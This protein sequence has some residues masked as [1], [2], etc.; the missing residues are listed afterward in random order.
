MTTII[1][2]EPNKRQQQEIHSLVN[3]CKTYE[4]IHISFPEDFDSDDD[5]YYILLYDNGSLVAAAASYLIDACTCEV[6]AFT[7]PN[8]RRKGC[9]KSI[10]S[11]IMHIYN[12]EKLN[13]LFLTDGASPD[14][15][16]VLSHLDFEKGQTEYFMRRNIDKNLK[17]SNIQ[18]IP[19]THIRRLALRHSKIF[20]L[21][22]KESTNYISNLLKMGAKA[23]DI[24]LGDNPI[25]LCFFLMEREE[26]Y[27]CGFGLLPAYQGQGY[28][29][30]ALHE[31]MSFIPDPIKAITLQVSDNNKKALALYKDYGFTIVEQ[32]TE[33]RSILD[34]RD[35]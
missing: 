5:Y 9:F 8:H 20:A 33:Y 4:P 26:A 31:M 35:I 18:F 15:N 22:L 27:L 12:L 32:I 34:E 7:L 16:A 14:T 2:K 30:K 3:T 17:D 10:L 13:L 6:S 24:S 25:G 29:K 21:S 28:A 23:F 1:T 11:S 19:S